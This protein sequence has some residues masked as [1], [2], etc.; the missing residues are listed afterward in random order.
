MYRKVAIN[1]Q[2]KKKKKKQTPKRPPV[3]KPP[4]H[5]VGKKSMDATDII[6]I[7]TK[8]KRT[9]KRLNDNS[10]D[11]DTKNWLKLI[12]VYINNTMTDRWFNQAAHMSQYAISGDY[13]NLDRGAKPVN[14][15]LK[16][17]EVQ[18]P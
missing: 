10:N 2:L 11:D 15:L 12:M 16:S 7:K 18:S 8:R 14:T 9:R 3:K 5:F 1:I 6:I 4:G 13:D 17:Y